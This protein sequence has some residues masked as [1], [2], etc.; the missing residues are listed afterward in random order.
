MDVGDPMSSSPWSLSSTE[1]RL[2]C[3]ILYSC[4]TL[5]SESSGSSHGAP[6]LGSKGMITFLPCPFS[7]ILS[8]S[9]EILAFIFLA[10][11]RPTREG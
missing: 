9:N 4:L 7:L 10:H 11:G 2:L 3:I 6:Y 5:A 8:F 1:S